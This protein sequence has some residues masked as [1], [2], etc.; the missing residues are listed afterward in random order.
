[1]GR[2]F[3][4]LLVAVAAVL[5]VGLAASA[6]APAKP[7]KART[8]HVTIRL[9]EGGIP[10]ILSDSWRGLGFGYGYSLARE[11]ICSMAQIYTTVRGERS[12]YFG[13]TATWSFSGNGATYTNLT[14]DLYFRRVIAEHR[15]E[16]LIRRPVPNGPRPAIKRAVNGYVQGYN[17]YL[18]RVGVDHL[19]DPTCRGAAWVK[20]ISVM[21]AYR[22]FFMLGILAGEGT[23]LDGIVDAAPPGTPLAIRQAGTQVTDP[24]FSDAQK[25][26]QTRPDIGSNAVALGKNATTT[27]KGMLLGNPHFPW[28]GSER[29]FESQLTYPGHMNASGASLLGVPVILIGHT[30][31][32]AWSHTVSTA[33]RFVPFQET[34]VPGSPTSYYV[35]GQVKQMTPTT[36]TVP[37]LDSDGSMRD[38]TRTMYSTIHGPVVISLQGQSLFGWTGDNAYAMHDV[39][40]DSF[41]FLNHFFDASRAQ[42]VGRMLRILRKD[43]GVP[44]VNTIAADSKGDTLYADIGAIPNVTDQ[45]TAECNTPLGQVTLSAAGIPVLDGSRGSCDLGQARGAV[46]KGIL[47]PSEE[48]FLRGADYVT[49]SND[50]YWLSNPMHPLEGFPRQ[51]G[52]ERTPRG[53]RTRLGL[54]MV[55]QRLAGADGR[56]GRRFSPPDLR[57]LITNNRVLGAE[58]TRD[59]LVAYCQANPTLNG[60]SGPVDVSGACPVLAAWDLTYNLDSPGAI[61]FR[62]FASGALASS[63]SMWKVPFDPNDPVNTP[64]TLN[65]DDPSVGRALAN[66]VTDLQGAGI[67]LDGKLRD[68]QYVVRNG[69]KIP[70]PGGP[71]PNGA[72][73]VITNSFSSTKGIGDITHGSSFIIAASMTGKNCPNVKTILT[74]SQAATNPDSAHYADQTQLFSQGSWLTDRFCRG[75][76]LRSPKLHVTRFGG[77]LFRRGF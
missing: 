67:P 33:F 69:A 43:Q 14:G 42:S 11:N 52:T 50:S 6:A 61:L 48:P 2:R 51:I 32:L 3:V 56:S 17:R 68:Y 70:I 38:V 12:M 41:R 57:N 44:W 71:G 27:R 58:L 31:S 1:M 24:S 45:K 19:P 15:V 35:D 63:G 60:S 73:D 25:L 13:P 7:R 9:T 59:D 46:D 53:L 66:A 34:L 37:V 21:D 5:I 74:Y 64:N 55:A 76:Q 47:S 26:E 22:R 18:A 36:V 72:F 8:P 75:Q 39:N 40:T 62:R 16:K 49:N 54:V 77:G 10:R 23:S 65:T 29:F 30:R 4:R 28:Q 20:P